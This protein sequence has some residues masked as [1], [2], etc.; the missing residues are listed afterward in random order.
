MT[1]SAASVAVSS[2]ARRLPE[3]VE[4]GAFFVKEQDS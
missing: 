3:A 4:Y 2:K 1:A